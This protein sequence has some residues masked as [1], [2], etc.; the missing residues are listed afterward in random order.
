MEILC[1]ELRQGGMTAFGLAHFKLGQKAKTNRNQ[2]G[3]R[4]KNIAK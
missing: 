3:E 1:H 2:Y 4:S